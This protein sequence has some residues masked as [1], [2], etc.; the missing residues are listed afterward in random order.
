MQIRYPST[1]LHQ[2][3]DDRS[4]ELDRAILQK[5][6]RDPSLLEIAKENIHHWLKRNDRGSL[7]PTLEWKEILEHSPFDEILSWLDREDDEAV[8]LRQ[9]SPF[10]GILSDQERTAIFKRYEPARTRTHYSRLV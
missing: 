5:I 4:L 3:I 2:Y 10:V 8:R 9:S 1:M 6:R 7:D